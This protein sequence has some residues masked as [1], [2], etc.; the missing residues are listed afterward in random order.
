MS[1]DL[2]LLETSYQI[3]RFIQSQFTENSRDGSGKPWAALDAFR[4]GPKEHRYQTREGLVLEGYYGSPSYIH[5]PYGRWSILGSNSGNGKIIFDAI[6]E[7]LGLKLIKDG[8]QVNSQIHMGPFWAITKWKYVEI[9]P[10]VYRE[11]S[12]Y[13]P[14]D[15]VREIWKEFAKNKGLV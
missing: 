6:R 13:I 2:S 8:E 10:P 7:P 12:E 9:S 4:D 14:S 1:F 3:G 11:E 15:K 5:T